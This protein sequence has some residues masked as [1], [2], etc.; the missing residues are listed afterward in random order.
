MKHGLQLHIFQ[1]SQVMVPFMPQKTVSMTF[2]TDSCPQIFF[3][4]FGSQC[5]STSSTFPL[6]QARSC[7]LMFNSFFLLKNASLYTSH[8]KF[9]RVCTLYSFIK[10]PWSVVKSVC[11]WPRRPGVQFQVKSYQ[12]LKKWYL[13]PPCLT[14]SII[15]YGS[16]VKWVNSKKGVAPS[17]TIEKGAFGLTSTTVANFTYISIK[18][19][20][21]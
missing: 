4:F 1:A 7:K 6:T 16:R 19:Y 17:P 11:Q 9:H 8:I 13:M 18:A 21:N 3:F 14:H 20:N 5:A 15:S 2:S 12:R 10:N